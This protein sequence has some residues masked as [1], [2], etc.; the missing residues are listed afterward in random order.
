[1]VGDVAALVDYDNDAGHADYVKPSQHPL[2]H[3]IRKGTD[4]SW[5][6]QGPPDEVSF[7]RSGACQQS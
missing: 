4:Q 2:S 1:M 3:K 5:S 6:G 7:A